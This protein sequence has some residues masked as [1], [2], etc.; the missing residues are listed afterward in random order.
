MVCLYCQNGSKTFSRLEPVQDLNQTPEFPIHDIVGTPRSPFRDIYECLDC[1][2]FWWIRVKGTGDP[3]STYPEYYEQTAVLLDDQRSELIRNPTV[4]RLLQHTESQFPYTFFPEVLESIATNERDSLKNIFLDRVPH[5]PSAVKLWLRSWFQTQFPEEYKVQKEQGFPNKARLVFTWESN[6]LVLVSEWI[7]IDQFVVLSV[8]DDSYTI[9]AFQLPEKKILWKQK[10]GRPFLEGISIPNLFYHSG[11]LCYYQGFQKGSEYFSKLNRPNEL[12]VFDL[13][14]NLLLHLPL[15]FRSYEILSTE[16]RDVSENRVVHNFQFSIL[17]NTL[18]IPYSNEVHIYDLQ[19]KELLQKIKTPNG[20]PFSGKA[21]ETESGV[22]LFHTVKGVFAVNEKW[23]VEYQYHSQFHPVFID[24]QLNF[25]Y[26]YSI[27]DQIQTGEQKR[28]IQN[29]DSGSN[30]L[31][32]L[33]S[34]PVEFPNGILTPFAWDKTYL[35]NQNLEITKEL[36][37]TSSDTLGPH[38]FGTNKIPILV[39]EDRICI[40]NDF[41]SIIMI[42]FIGNLICNHPIQSEVIQVLSFDGK[43]SVVILSCFDEY[44]EEDQIELFFLDPKGTILLKKILPGPE[45]LSVSFDGILVFAQNNK[46]YTLDMFQESDF[47]LK[48]I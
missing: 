8:L 39:T 29:D 42:D 34:P 24:S 9:T 12:L 48:T 10:L 40:T 31:F 15:S 19:S 37:F 21:F 43:H 17:S 4:S 32:E 28:F 1:H 18:Y 16:E 20:D 46:I 38:A 3:R 7:A 6:E 47:Y 13:S 5:L 14:G 27:V 22:I 45:G 33:V 35:L 23:E 2:Q 26:Y 41:R 30:L 36:N 44:S 11:Y 25:Y